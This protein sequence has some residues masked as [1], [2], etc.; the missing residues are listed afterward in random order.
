MIKFA[1][2]IAAAA[3]LAGLLTALPA[4]NVEAG[5]PALET[6]APKVET[7][8]QS[9]TT[10]RSPV[11]T[12]AACSQRAWPYYDQACLVGSD[13]RPRSEPRKVRLIAI[14]RLK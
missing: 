10:D 12:A 2:T 14:D 4:P 9:A 6:A 11:A 7:P 1:I 8:V 3:A 5:T 13:I